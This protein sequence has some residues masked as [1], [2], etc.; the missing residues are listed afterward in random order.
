VLNA[1]YISE[2][3]T[4]LHVPYVLSRR[5]LYRL[6]S[7]PNFLSVFLT[8]IFGVSVDKF[9]RR[10]ALL[11]SAALLLGLA[12]TIIFTHAMESAIFPLLLIGLAFRCVMSSV[13][14]I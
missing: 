8:P 7:I 6:Q 13:V 11:M 1:L 2:F 4:E 5:V 12:H 10:T 3:R 9:G 14:V